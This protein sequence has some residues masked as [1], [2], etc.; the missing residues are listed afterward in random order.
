LY[1][2]A[3]AQEDS[4]LAQRLARRASGTHPSLPLARYAGLY[5]DPAYGDLRVRVEGGRLVA[6]VGPRLAGD[7]EHWNWD[8][9]RLRFREPGDRG[10]NFLTF[11][12]GPDGT[13]ETATIE[14]LHPFHRVEE[15]AAGT[16]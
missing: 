9:F 13:P 10:D 16:R 7:L 15:P 1:A 5:R 12:L 2:A 6:T 14:G 8:T 11:A 4:A 3:A